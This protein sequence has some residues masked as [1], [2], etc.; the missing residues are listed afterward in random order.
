[1]ENRYFSDITVIQDS[2]FQKRGTSIT[3]LWC[4]AKSSPAVARKVRASNGSVQSLCTEE[5]SR[6]FFGQLK[7]E[8]RH[9]PTAALYNKS[10]TTH[11]SLVSIKREVNMKANNKVNCRKTKLINCGKL[12][13]GLMGLHQGFLRWQEWIFFRFVYPLM[14]NFKSFRFSE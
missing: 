7:M 11:F 3:L 14:Q 4:T 13:Q 1:M 2:I 6:V 12:W 5:H 8:S 10:Q 9:V